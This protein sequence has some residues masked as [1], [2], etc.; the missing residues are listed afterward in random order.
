[1]RQLLL[2]FII[3]H[4]HTYTYIHS[5]IHTTPHSCSIS[6]SSYA[7]C[8]STLDDAAGNLTISGSD[9][10]TGLGGVYP[11]YICF[12]AMMTFIVVCRVL[13]YLSLRFLHRP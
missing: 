6:E 4:S 9:V 2:L 10:L 5:L 13:A 7:A 8:N 12:L 1:M 11:L 3:C